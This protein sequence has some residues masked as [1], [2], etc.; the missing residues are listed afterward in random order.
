MRLTSPPLSYIPLLPILCGV[1]AGVLFGRYL[2]QYQLLCVGLTA[3]AGFIAVV[4][5]RPW[6]AEFSLSMALSVTATALSLPPQFPTSPGKGYVMEGVVTEVV[7][8]ASGQNADVRVAGPDGSFTTRVTYPLFNP[9]LEAGDKIRFTGTYSLPRR[10]TD[11]PLEDDMAESYFNNGISLL[12]YVRDGDLELTGRSGNLLYLFKR[13]R[14]AIVDRIYSSGLDEPTAIFLAAVLTGDTSSLT[15]SRR[16]DYASAGV[17]HILALSGAHVAI[18]AMVVSI[19]LFPLVVAGHRRLRWWVTIAVLWGYA[20]LTGM[21]PSVCRAVIMASAV[22]LALIFDRP[23]SSLNALCLA[24]ILIL[25][26]SPLSLFNAGFQLSFAATLC[27]I[28]FSPKLMPQRGVKSRGYRALSFLAVTLAA[29]LGTMPLV[30]WH[31]HNIPLFFLPANIAAV[32][33]MPFMIT[34]GLLLLGLL[35]VGIDP[36]WLVSI[37]DFVYSVFDSA[38]HF[39]ATMPGTTVTRIYISGWL[40]VPAYVALA[41][42]CAFLYRRRWNYAVLTCATLLF[43]VGVADALRPQ[44]PDGDAYMLRSMSATTIAYHS[45]DTLRVFTLSPPHSYPADSLVIAD[46]YCDYLAT[47]GIRHIDISS[48]DS[49]VATSRGILPFGHRKMVVAHAVGNSSA[50]RNTHSGNNNQSD[51]SMVGRVNSMDQSDYCLITAKWYGNPVELSKMIN[52]DTIVLSR[53]I[54]RRRRERYYRE[55]ASAGIPVI[56]LGTRPLSSL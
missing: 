37:L 20:V 21:S 25:L 45:G 14:A 13:M 51:N 42:F 28:L 41:F 44:F 39:V 11:L 56:D 34:G 1:V 31:F 4:F 50:S 49:V 40:L 5:R 35:L 26:F 32:A 7:Q 43:T 9:T 38:V 36:A 55:L 24:A 19:L 3:L 48:L 12:C 53:D 16:Q 29:T 27:I 33:V 17:A 30:A 18:I 8:R 6:P 2:P 52:A 46:R 15:P 54:N 22:L 10:D 47:R 23:R